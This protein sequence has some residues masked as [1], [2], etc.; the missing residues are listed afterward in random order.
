MT[1]QLKWALLALIAI[2]ALAVLSLRGGGAIDP[3][4]KEK[5]PAEAPKR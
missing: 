1:S 4:V 2:V 5:P 3:G